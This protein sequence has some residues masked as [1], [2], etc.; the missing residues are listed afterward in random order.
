MELKDLILQSR[1]RMEKIQN[2]LEQKEFKIEARINE[3]QVIIDDIKFMNQRAEL[4]MDTLNRFIK[5]DNNLK[6][7]MNDRFC[8]ASNAENDSFRKHL[9]SNHQKSQKILKDLVLKISTNH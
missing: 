6:M 8:F 3:A 5:L 4:L 1:F 7:A 9:N 2:A